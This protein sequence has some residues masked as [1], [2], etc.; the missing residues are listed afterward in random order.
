MQ[1]SVRL[2]IYD[3]TVLQLWPSSPISSSAGGD[4]DAPPSV[5]FSTQ[6]SIATWEMWDTI[7]S[8]CNY[9]PRLTL[10]ESSRPVRCVYSF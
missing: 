1:L 10:S 2:P 4:A 8:I 6:P 3:A 9:N 5:L 7:R